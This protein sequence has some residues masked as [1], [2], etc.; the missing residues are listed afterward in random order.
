[1]TFSRG[2][3][4]FALMDRDTF[5]KQLG[6]WIFGLLRKSPEGARPLIVGLSAP[7]GAGK[8][9]LTGDLCRRAEAKGLRAVSLS[10]DDFYLTHREQTELARQNPSNPYLQHR[11][12]PGTH[13]VALA[14][15][16]LLR[17]KHIGAGGSVAIPAYDKSAREGAGDRR[18]KDAWPQINGP[19]DFVIFEGWMLGF[20][21]LPPGAL[22]DPAMSAIN[23][24]LGAYSAW[25]SL[26]DA[27]I[28]LEPED[29]LFTVAWRIEA[30]RNMKAAGRPGMT[31]AEVRAFI[32]GFIPAYRTYLPWLAGHLPA[33]PTLHLVIG[34]DR[35][36]IAAF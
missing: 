35:L 5:Y 26:L 3:G 14:T 29:P 25:T 31:D 34:R 11:G 33:L 6:D 2:R 32:E 21:P 20:T 10:V 28:W 24:R 15:D 4:D 17:L 18:P 13:D 36:P 1:L 19:L 16:T 30:E 27:F 12:Y 8:T 7:Q 9:T 23:G 22:H